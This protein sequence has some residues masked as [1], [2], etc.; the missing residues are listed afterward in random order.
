[1]APCCSFP[2][3][4]DRAVHGAQSF[5]HTHLCS[6]GTAA[7][8]SSAQLYCTVITLSK[9]AACIICLLFTSNIQTLVYTSLLRAL[10]QHHANFTKSDRASTS[11]MSK[12]GHSADPAGPTAGT[13]PRQKSQVLVPQPELLCRGLKDK[14]SHSAIKETNI[15]SRSSWED[16]EE[17]AYSLYLTQTWKHQD[18]FAVEQEQTQPKFL[19]RNRRSWQS[20]ARETSR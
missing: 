5:P 6:W 19:K 9:G 8:H 14:P 18:A 3:A 4:E 17:P 13:G 20:R 10:L 15:L 2:D 16:A 1:M 12:A 11:A 7:C